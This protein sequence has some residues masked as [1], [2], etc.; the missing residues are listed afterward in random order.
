MSFPFSV[1][2]ARVAGSARRRAA[3]TL[4]ELMVTMGVGVLLIVFLFQLFN[5]TINAWRNGEDQS[6]TYREA[7]AAMQIMVRDIGQT[8][9]AFPVNAYPS[10]T[11]ATPTPTPTPGSAAPVFV[12]DKYALNV[13]TAEPTPSD[14]YSINEEL[15]CLTNVPNNGASSLCAVGYC[16][17]WGPDLIAPDD[18]QFAQ[19]SASAP[20][21]YAL[22]RQFLGSGKG[23][24]DPNTGHPVTPGLFSR[25]D[26]AKNDSPLTFQDIFQRARP[27]LIYT[28]TP[29]PAPFPPLS[30]GTVLS[31]Y[32]WDLQFRTPDTIT[33]TGT[34]PAP[35]PSPLPTATP[36]LATAPF[37]AT[38]PPYVEIRFKALSAR[39]ARKLEG[40][41][42]V[43]PTTWNDANATGSGSDARIYQQIILPGT[44]QFVARVPLGNA[45]AVPIQ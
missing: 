41:T 24:V 25:F 23:P 22:V 20:R 29:S 42:L 27:Q 45:S 30:V 5:A 32:I 8:A 1:S 10:P 19:K 31:S 7:R 12:I 16:C 36:Y 11:P 9:A 13:N 34:F 28:P 43:G 35:S 2:S 37:S 33:Q 38:L 14:S 44:R 3:F 18:P 15:Y 26:S 40:N 21:A 4:M 6:D 39:A 17:V